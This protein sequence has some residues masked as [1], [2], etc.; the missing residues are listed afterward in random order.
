MVMMNAPETIR[1]LV[2]TDRCDR[3]TAAAT[4]AVQFNSGSELLFCGHHYNDHAEKL[5]F[6]GAVITGMRKDGP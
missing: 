3:C 6:S 2:A 1:E 5:V 4:I